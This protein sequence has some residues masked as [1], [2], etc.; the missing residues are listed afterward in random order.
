LELALAG[1]ALARN[2][3]TG[4]PAAV[5]RIMAEVR[6]L[7]GEPS[8]DRFDAP[9]RTVSDGYRE[10]SETYDAP[11]NWLVELDGDAVHAILAGAPAGDALDAACGTGRHAEFLHRQGH[12]VVGVDASPEMLAQARRRLPDA[13]LRRG[14]L[15][16]LPLDAAAVDLAVCSL[17]LTHLAALELAMRELAR[18]V[19]PGGRFVLSDVHPCCVLLGGQALYATG[20][21]ERA[22]VTNHLHWHGRYLEAFAAAGLAV[23]A[24]RDVAMR[25]SETDMLASKLSVDADVVAEALVGMPA[26]LVWELSRT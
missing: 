13:D 12:R 2:W 16:A 19:R 7:A 10:W 24:C 17:A 23:D 15:E 26:V 22:Y 21:G 11:G 14:E 9:L 1:M 8:G 20:A 4:E 6:R 3:L 5:D 25:R 18:V